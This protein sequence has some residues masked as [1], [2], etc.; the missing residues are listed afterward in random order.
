MI[1]AVK[2]T[3]ATMADRQATATWQGDIKSGKGTM[4]FADYEGN[5]VIHPVLKKVPVPTRKS[6]WGLHMPDAM[7][8][9]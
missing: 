4:H 8:C 1:S 7:P 6:C 9:P 2:E 5:S 3:G